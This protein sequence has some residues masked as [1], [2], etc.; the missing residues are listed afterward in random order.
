MRIKLTNKEGK[1][2]KTVAI[3]RDL[4]IPDAI[5]WQGSIYL[6]AGSIEYQAVTFWDVR[7]DR[8]R[9]FD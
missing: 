7:G 1:T 4:A 2:L 9:V 5:Y 8:F 6:R 3:A